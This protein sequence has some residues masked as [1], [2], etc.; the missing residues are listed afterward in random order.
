MP[1]SLHQKYGHLIFSTKN[2][3]QIITGEVEPRLYEY[4]GGIVRGMNAAILEINGIPDHVHLLI[5]ESKSVADQD[6][7]GQLKGES[8]R[9]MN[10][11]FPEGSRFAWQS[12]YGWFSVSAKDVDA[13]ASYVRNQKEHH[14]TVTFQDE[15]RKF[16]KQYKV[17]FDERYV[18]D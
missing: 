5:R 7:I 3:D 1:Q 4:M 14:Q 10:K 16:L 18:W 15:Y 11:T 12:G 9:W 6:F 17:E 8:S 13:A 2:R